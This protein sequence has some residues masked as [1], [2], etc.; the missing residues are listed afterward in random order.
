VEGCAACWRG[1]KLA[2]VIIFWERGGGE[3]SVFFGGGEAHGY[4]IAVALKIKKKCGRLI[5]SHPTKGKGKEKPPQR[6][7]LMK[8]EGSNGYRIQRKK[9]GGNLRQ[10]KKRGEKRTSTEKS[11]A[12][13]NTKGRVTLPKKKIFSQKRK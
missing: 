3:K 4:P 10:Q 5:I 13:E 11:P 12:R 7:A 8:S 2:G 6:N 1:E 9:R